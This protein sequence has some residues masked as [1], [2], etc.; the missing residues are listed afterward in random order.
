MITIF[1][2]GKIF[3]FCCSNITDLSFFARLTLSIL[4]CEARDGE[5]KKGGKEISIKQNKTTT[6]FFFTH[7]IRVLELGTWLQIINLELPREREK[8]EWKRREKK[9]KERKKKQSKEIDCALKK[10]EK[11]VIS[12]W[13]LETFFSIFLIFLWYTLVLFLK[14]EK[15]EKSIAF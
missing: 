6:P 10:M 1:S 4:I 12:R 3:Y 7:S 15:K 8:K 14:K 11:M 2:L 13:K 5:W 9:K